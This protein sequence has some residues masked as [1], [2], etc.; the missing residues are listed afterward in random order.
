MIFFINIQFESATL[1]LIPKP[2]NAQGKFPLNSSQIQF[3]KQMLSFLSA[4]IQFPSCQLENRKMCLKFLAPP[5]KQPCA[6]SWY[7]ARL[8]MASHTSLTGTLS[9]HN[10]I[11]CITTK[12]CCECSGLQKV[13]SWSDLCAIHTTVATAQSVTGSEIQNIFCCDSGHCAAY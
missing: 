13:Y 6:P 3:K 9:Q 5:V 7:I 1:V 2:L 10:L 4:K 8:G 11:L 12:A